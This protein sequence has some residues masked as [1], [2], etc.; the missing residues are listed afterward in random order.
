M[1]PWTVVKKSV[2]ILG[3]LLFL[4]SSAFAQAGKG[5]LVLSGRVLAEDGSPAAGIK[6]VALLNYEKSGRPFTQRETLTDA[7][8]KWA[9][10]FIKQGT[11]V[12]AAFAAETMSE[13]KQVRL[14][15]NRDDVVLVLIRKADDILVEAKNAIYREDFAKAGDIL[16]WFLQY[17]PRSRERDSALFWVAYVN[18]RLVADTDMSW[19]SKSLLEKA[20]Q[21]LERLIAES[22]SSEW[23]EDA[24]ILRLDTALRLYQRGERQYG[25]VIRKG[26][27]FPDRPDVRLAALDALLIVDRKQAFDELRAI[28]LHDPDPE[29]R[30]KAILILGRSG[31][32][33]A[34]AL[35][36]EV[37]SKDSDAGVKKAA[38][39]WLARRSP[40]PD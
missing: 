8:G 30:K 27:S 7:K 35:L 3:A 10:P 36:E 22:P 37:A 2:G 20:V 34:L 15:T 11:W 21:N 23:R 24:E 16:D 40:G 5:N 19:S 12:V 14:T 29:V 4:G 13:L 1:V 6:V 17:F 28:V 9:V 25:E 39:L 32:K 26:V 18:N 33:E 38:Q 31:G